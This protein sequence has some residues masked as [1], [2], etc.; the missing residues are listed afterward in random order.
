[1]L[2]ECT[3]L[4]INGRFLNNNWQGWISLKKSS[5]L[6]FRIPILMFWRYF[7]PCLWQTDHVLAVKKIQLML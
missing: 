2:W 5:N 4:S 1:M 6:L 3:F 7:T